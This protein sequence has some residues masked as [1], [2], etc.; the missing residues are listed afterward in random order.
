MKH[1]LLKVLAFAALGGAFGCDKAE[2]PTTPLTCSFQLLNEQGQEAA[3][4][5]QGQN[6][7]FRLL[8][9]NPT[10]EVVV[11]NNPAFDN[12]AFLA[13]NRLTPGE[14]TGALGK[15]YQTMFCEYVQGLPVP[16]RGT[17]EL[18]ISWVETPSTPSRGPFCAHAPTTWLPVGRYRTSFPLA[19]TVLRGGHTTVTAAQTFS[20]EFEVQ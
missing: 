1:V 8:I 6:I 3:V 16:A 5:P 11:L 14:G 20:K 15:P 13:V 18:S 2:A 17:L 10:G 7:R 9:T 4:F 12:A 19:L